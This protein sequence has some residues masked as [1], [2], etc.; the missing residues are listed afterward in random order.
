MRE[1]G[2]AAGGGAP[3]VAGEHDGG[4]GRDFGVFGDGV[5][6]GIV[7][8]AGGEIGE[9][10]AAEDFV[11]RFPEALRG[12]GEDFGGGVVGNLADGAAFGGGE[13][14]VEAL[15][16]RGGDGDEGEVGGGGF[17]L[18]VFGEGD[19]DAGGVL[20]DGGDFGALVDF[21]FQFFDER[22]GDLV[23]AADDFVE[24]L[25]PDVE[26][27]FAQGFGA[28]VL[29]LRFLPLRDGHEFDGFLGHAGFFRRGPGGRGNRGARIF[30][31]L[32]LVERRSLRSSSVK[33]FTAA[34]TTSAQR[35]SEDLFFSASGRLKRALIFLTS[36]LR[37][38]LPRT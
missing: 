29:H 27:F 26:H 12:H 32:G 23:G 7:G 10:A 17:G 14:D 35:S 22:A 31:D 19:F 30:S 18:A 5:V 9:G 38:F 28:T 34:V 36:L 16:D 2:E 20:G 21:G 25:G 33:F 13:V 4:G 8:G 24:A 15:E 3:G 11:A 1:G 6:G 37:N